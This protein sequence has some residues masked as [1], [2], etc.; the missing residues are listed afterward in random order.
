MPRPGDREDLAFGS[1]ERFEAIASAREGLPAG[2]GI[3]DFGDDEG[4]YANEP[5]Q[6]DVRAATIDE[7]HEY[8]GQARYQ[9]LTIK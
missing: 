1:E 5:V 7:V 6:T 4:D 3:G 2:T 9:D 8:Y